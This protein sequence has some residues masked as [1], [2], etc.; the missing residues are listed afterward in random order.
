MTLDSSREVLV[1]PSNV[2]FHRSDKGNFNTCEVLIVNKSARTLRFKVLSTARSRYTLST[3]KG[4]LKSGE[5]VKTDI[6]VSRIPVNDDVA[7][8]F[9]KVQFFDSIDGSAFCEHYICSTI[10]RNPSQNVTSRDSDS[11]ST[12]PS[13]YHDVGLSV[14]SLRAASLSRAIGD[15]VGS[16]KHSVNSK[17]YLSVD[18]AKSLV[19]PNFSSTMKV[20]KTITNPNTL[21]IGHVN[22][23]SETANSK[24]GVLLLYDLFYSFLF[25][26]SLLVCLFGILLPFLPYDSKLWLLS[27]ILRESPKSDYP[28]SMPNSLAFPYHAQKAYSYAKFY[29]QTPSNDATYSS[30]TTECPAG[31]NLSKDEFNRQ[32][33]LAFV[34]F[35]AAFHSIC[36]ALIALDPSVAIANM[37]WFCLGLLIMYRWTKRR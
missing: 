6:S 28:A 37:S 15:L 4:L 16:E 5:F 27:K 30:T 25:L 33:H 22:N 34:A 8:D 31:D 3:C 14:A 10:S 12:W 7:K 32:T 35:K 11:C 9:F 19:F 17:A 26:L 24:T 2:F 36:K 21:K 13:R 23:A 29:K 20:Q 1:K 18:R